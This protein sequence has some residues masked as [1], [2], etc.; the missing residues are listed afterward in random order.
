MRLRLAEEMMAH[1][2]AAGLS[3]S[4]FS[5][6]LTDQTDREILHYFLHP[7]PI[8]RNVLS[9]TQARA[10]I[11]FV[12]PA[13]PSTWKDTSSEEPL[14]YL[15][16]STALGVAV[17]SER[18]S[19]AFSNAEQ[20]LFEQH[21]HCFEALVVRHRDLHKLEAAETR[22]VQV[23]KDLLA[24]YDGSYELSGNTQDEV[25][26]NIIRMVINRMGFD[27]AG[28][29]LRDSEQDLLRGLWGVDE[30]GEIAPISGTVFRLSPERRPPLLL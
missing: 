19:T 23:D 25:A 20:T 1:M 7:G 6:Y 14:W 10:M 4:A 8:G 2:R 9:P 24:L 22:I 18:R 11:P 13:A 15:A 27:R 17:I 29:F 26:Q 12:T 28:I 16:V 21:A 5:I 30:R 3:F